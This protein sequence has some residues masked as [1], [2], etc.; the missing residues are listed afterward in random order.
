MVE[1]E[2]EEVG[3]GA[4]GGGGGSEMSS[5]TNLDGPHAVHRWRIEAGVK[6]GV[7]DSF[8]CNDSATTGFH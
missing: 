2:E 8:A 1:E 5:V 3:R 6:R 4:N 7:D